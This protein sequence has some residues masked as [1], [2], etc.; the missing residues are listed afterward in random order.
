MFLGKSN[1]LKGKAKI[2]SNIICIN[3]ADGGKLQ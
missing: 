2:P 3:S 1:L